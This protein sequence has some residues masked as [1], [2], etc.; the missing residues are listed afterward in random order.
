VKPKRK[1]ATLPRKMSA[2][3]RLGLRDLAKV[4]RSK[5]FT[6]HMGTWLELPSEGA[7]CMVCFAGS[8]MAKSLG[9]VPPDTDGL[10]FGAARFPEDFS[11]RNASALYALNSLRQGSVE[12][13][14]A[15]LL[16]ANPRRFGRLNRRVTSYSTSPKR[17][18]RDMNKLARDLAKEGL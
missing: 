12:G 5:R 14:A 3:I 1:V 6:V 2:L 10:P 8:V 15:H 16:R 17:W 9:S 7:K 4:E 11:D 18:R 13:A